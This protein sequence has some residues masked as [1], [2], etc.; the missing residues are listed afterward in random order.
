[1]TIGVPPNDSSVV[2]IPH[3]VGFTTGIGR[4]IVT[5]AADADATATA[6]NAVVGDLFFA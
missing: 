2:T 6:A 3:G 1:M 5:G 4:T